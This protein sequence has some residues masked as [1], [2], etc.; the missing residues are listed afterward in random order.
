MQI[1]NIPLDQIQPSPTNPRKIFDPKDLFDLAASIKE[2]GV[3]QPILVRP[4]TLWEQAVGFVI[5]QR[6]RKEAF[7]AALAFVS[8]TAAHRTQ[9][10]FT[11]DQVEMM[12][13]IVSSVCSETWSDVVKAVARRRGITPDQKL[14]HPFEKLILKMDSG[15]IVGLL[16][17][18]T[19]ARQMLGWS[20]STYVSDI[21]A[22]AKALLKFFG[23]DV[24]A[25]EKQAKQGLVAKAK[26]KAKPKAKAKA[27]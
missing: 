2:K 25:A 22:Q 5:N 14:K 20:T 24:K 6:A 8:E 12:Q 19:L 11:E 27:A 4:R 21:N 18:L 15:E 16:A 9:D 26:E 23:F 1:E 3:L 17:E 7:K 13:L 10:A